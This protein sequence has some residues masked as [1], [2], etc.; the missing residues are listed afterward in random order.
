MVVN[1]TQYLI[2]FAVMLVAGLTI[3]TLT[4]RVRRQAELAR[5]NER[6]IEALYRLGRK[7][8]GIVGEDF[9]AA[10]TERAV[11]EFLGGEAAV[12]IPRN[13]QLQPIL[14]H[15]AKFAADPSEIAVAQWVFDHGQPAGHGTD[16]LPSARRSTYRSSPRPARSACWRCAIRDAAKAVAA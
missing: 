14:D 16:T 10:E 6:R 3:A 2:T 8:T 5:G 9:I 11:S 7:L 4:A 15:R 1:D 13:G 12:F